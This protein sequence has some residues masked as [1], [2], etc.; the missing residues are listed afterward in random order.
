MRH[1]SV[2]RIAGNS[3]PTEPGFGC[4][5]SSPGDRVA[6]QRVLNQLADSAGKLRAETADEGILFVAQVEPL[7]AY[8][9]SN[10]RALTGQRFHDLDVG[11]G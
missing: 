6:H 8:G 9:R 7:G 3:V 5:S 2:Q 11:A 1:W 4:G 10:H